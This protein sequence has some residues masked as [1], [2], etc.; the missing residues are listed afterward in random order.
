M[1]DLA[2]AAGLL[3]LG[4]VLASDVD[5]QGI[6]PGGVI[7]Y[8]TINLSGSIAVTNTFQSVQVATST[9][10]GCL[11]QN[12]TGS[13]TEYVFFGPI[14]NATIATAIALP[15]STIGGVSCGLPPG[16]VVTDQISITGT[17]GDAY[18]AAVQ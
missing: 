16:G 8:T 2:L 14:A 12:N 4:T 18:Y 3:A 15:P 17:S 5:A 10:A 13:H 7:R 6:G 1:K 11:I 9:R